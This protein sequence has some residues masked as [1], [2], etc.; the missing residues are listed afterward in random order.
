M[1]ANKLLESGK[2][3]KHST[4]EKTGIM[5]AEIKKNSGTAGTDVNFAYIYPDGKI[6]IVTKNNNHYGYGHFN[7]DGYIHDDSNRTVFEIV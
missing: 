3:Q 7:K 5:C 1:D 6:D 4:Y 2:L